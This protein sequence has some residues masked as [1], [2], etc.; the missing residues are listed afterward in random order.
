MNQ[1]I[2]QPF[3]TVFAPTMSLARYDGEA[4]SAVEIVASDRLELHPAA[5]V[6]HY[7]STCFEGLKAYRHPDGSVAVFRLNDHIKRMENSAKALSLPPPPSDMLEQMIID[8]LDEHR[9]LVPEAPA[10]MYIRPTLIGTEPSIGKAAAPSSTAMCFVLLSIVGDYFSGGVR[11]LTLLVEDRFGRAAEGMGRVKTGANYASALRMI[12]DAREQHPGVDQ[13]LF[14]PNGD[15]Q[16][17][18][19]ANFMLING[20]RLITKALDD[21]FLHGI[22]RDSILQIA[23]DQGYRI[24]ERE[25]DTDELLALAGDS[26]AALSGTAAVLSGVGTLIFSGEKVAV[27]NGKVGEKTLALRQALVDLQAGIANDR[28]GWIT[29]I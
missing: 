16:E 1:A 15:V 17:T 21:S 9:S 19:A 10:A 26:E 24:E 13:V 6:L 14:S 8:L 3:G 20:D 12:I 4:W 22:T 29:R 11:P 27:G 7:A 18:G 23:R 28:H 5:H 25:L 2:H